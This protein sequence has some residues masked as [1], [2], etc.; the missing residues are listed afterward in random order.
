MATP[1]PVAKTYGERVL[2]GINKAKFRDAC[3]MHAMT[4]I[5][6][7]GQYHHGHLGV[8]GESVAHAAYFVADKMLEQRRGKPE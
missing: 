2:D 8:D 3:A 4:G 7:S 1:P 5:L 6:A